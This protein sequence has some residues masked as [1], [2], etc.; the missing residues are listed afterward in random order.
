MIRLGV[1]GVVGLSVLTLVASVMVLTPAW[2]PLLAAVIIGAVAV[3]VHVQACRRAL[4]R[5]RDSG[6]FR[7]LGF[8][9]SAAFDISIACSIS[10]T[11][12]WCSAALVEGHVVP[13]VGGF[14]PVISP[15]WYAGLVLLLAGIVLARGKS[16]LHAM[17]ALVSLVAAFTLTPALVY[18]MPRSQAAAKH[19]DLVQLILHA[20]HLD[21]EPAS[22]KRIP[23]FF[24]RSR[25][26]ATSLEYTTQSGWP[27]SGPLSSGSLGSLSCGSSSGGRS[28]PATG[29]GS[30]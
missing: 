26:C 21:A 8:S 19:V 16:E 14:L 10:G 15:L 23:G 9:W 28:A 1:A 2:H 6:V 24:R 30:A 13:G 29:S 3:G 18:G 12:L 5:L 22:I 4:P 7:S 27:P 17:S 25:G 20:H 11:M